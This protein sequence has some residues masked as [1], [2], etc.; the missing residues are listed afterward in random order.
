MV[1]IVLTGAMAGQT[2][3]LNNYHFENGALELAGT[4]KDNAGVIKY[5]K[6]CY[7]ATVEGEIESAA[8]TM[9]RLV[10]GGPDAGQT[11]KI[12]DYVFTDGVLLLPGSPE[13]KDGIIR[14]Y[15]RCYQ[16]RLD[17]GKCDV[18]KDQAGEVLS[19]VRS[20]GKEPAKE[21]AVELRG[22]DDPKADEGSELRAAGDGEDLEELREI[23]REL[24]PDVDSHWT[25]KGG[26]SW[27]TVKLK[28]GEEIPYEEVKAAWPEFDRDLARTLR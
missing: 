12:G 5:M 8:Q 17:N 11:V 20:D 28:L 18:Q 21:A 26:P 14:Y 6:R 9:T 25:K 2:T 7:K 27:A 13:V 1:R 24:D 15:S 10:L 16:A 3:E 22:N 4:H 19:D 23:L